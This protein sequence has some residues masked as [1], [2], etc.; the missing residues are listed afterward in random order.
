MLLDVMWK[1]RKDIVMKR[2]M[3]ANEIAA[4]EAAA[5]A[6]LAAP[7]THEMKGLLR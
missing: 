4:F 7:A 2:P 1:L 3:A 5:A 6:A